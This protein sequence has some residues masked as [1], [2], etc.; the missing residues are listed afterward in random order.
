MYVQGFGSAL[1]LVMV[2]VTC[3]L[4]VAIPGL[5]IVNAWLVNKSIGGGMACC[6]MI[7]LVGVF[8][9]I[10][11]NWGKPASFILLALLLLACALSPRVAA[12]WEK[13]GLARLDNEDI[14]KY[15]LALEHDPRNAAAHSYLAQ[16]Y[17]KQKRY[18][19]AIEHFQLSLAAYAESPKDR[20]LLQRAIDEKQRAEAEG[21]VCATCGAIN[22]PGAKT[23]GACDQVLKEPGFLRWLVQ[24]ENLKHVARTSVVACVLVTLVGATLSS[25]PAGVGVSLLFV[26]MTGAAAYLWFRL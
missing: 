24:P 22:P 20:H 1:S 9:M 18:D 3:S 14:R 16:I 11:G 15:Q 26:T 25:L 8:G 21:P 17:L 5:V 23:C 19:D 7:G 6:L 13:A 2:V 10:M 4:C 12:R